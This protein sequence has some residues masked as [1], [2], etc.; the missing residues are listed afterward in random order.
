LLIIPQHGQQ[1]D[2]LTPDMLHNQ[3]VLRCCIGKYNIRGCLGQN[4]MK[5]EWQESL[6]AV[7]VPDFSSCEVKFLFMCQ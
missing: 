2:Q 7:I 3:E 4:S 5:A 1:K 6:S